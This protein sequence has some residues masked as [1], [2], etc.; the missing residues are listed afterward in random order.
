MKISAIMTSKPYVLSPEQTIAEAARLFLHQQIDGAAVV[1]T[2]NEL[3]GLVGKTQLYEAL[4]ADTALKCP[5]SKIMITDV[6]TCR[7]DDD[8]DTII[9]KDVSRLPVIEGGK[10]VGIVTFSDLIRHYHMEIKDLKNIK[11]IKEQ[12]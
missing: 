2:Q 9:D 4:A 7:P 3:L 10:V 1:N 11:S 5:I 6:I 12:L 8:I